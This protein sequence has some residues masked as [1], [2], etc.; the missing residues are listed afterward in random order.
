M[1][2][3]IIPECIHFQHQT[4]VQRK[5]FSRRISITQ[6]SSC[7]SVLNTN[8][9]N[10]WHFLVIESIWICGIYVIPLCSSIQ[11]LKCAL[12]SA[13]ASSLIFKH[14]SWHGRDTLVN[15]VSMDGSIMRQANSSCVF[16]AC[17]N[18]PLTLCL[19][20]KCEIEFEK[21]KKIV[22]NQITISIKQK[23]YDLWIVKRI[24]SVLVTAQPL[25]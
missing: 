19:N 1:K 21:N 3:H 25:P 14:I 16:S 11:Q 22:K 10:T 8:T 13:C 5:C 24:Y 18:L 6:S 20:A 15:W 23:R 17:F 4:Q 9:G 2:F 7:Y 12:P